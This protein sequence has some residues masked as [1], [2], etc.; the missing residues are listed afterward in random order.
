MEEFKE[1]LK[2]TLRLALMAIIP[3][4]IS[5]LQSGVFDWKAIVIAG[6]IAILGG[7]DK[8]LHKLEKGIGGNGLTVF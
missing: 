5:Q 6:G 8:W 7:I 4:G 1:G 2:Q 3:L